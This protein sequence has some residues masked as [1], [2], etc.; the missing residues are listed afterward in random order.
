MHKNY[1]YIIAPSME[2]G[3]LF[4]KGFGDREDKLVYMGL[5]RVDDI[6]SIKTRPLRQEFNIGEDQEIILYAPTFRKGEDVPLSELIGAIKT[7]N[8]KAYDIYGGLHDRYVL[9]VKL[10]PLYADSFEEAEEKVCRVI[11]DNNYTTY[12]WLK[13]CDRIITDY[14]ALGVEASLT[15][16][17]LYFYLY[18]LEEYEESVGLNVNPALEVPQAV[19]K[20]GPELAE[21]MDREYDY[22]SLN[23]FRDKYI[24]VETTGCTAR[25][26]EFVANMVINR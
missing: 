7:L 20:S 13:V 1:D 24:S 14:S 15:A 6:L 12:D 25:L 22:E 21:I 2:T 11:I 23:K 19:A 16:K 8:K 26:G 5:P 10:H 9:V 4:C 17:P 18:D 3:R